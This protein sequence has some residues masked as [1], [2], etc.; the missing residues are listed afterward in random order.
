M[1]KKEN[2]NLEKIESLIFLAERRVHTIRLVWEACVENLSR[3][4]YFEVFW[5]DIKVENC[6]SKCLWFLYVWFSFR[7]YWSTAKLVQ[8]FFDLLAFQISNRW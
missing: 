6:K 8:F 2:K 5:I 7:I 4:G 1:Y 3:E